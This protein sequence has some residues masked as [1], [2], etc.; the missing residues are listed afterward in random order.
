MTMRHPDMVSASRSTL[1][2]L[3]ALAALVVLGGCISAPSGGPA[4]DASSP[5]GTHDPTGTIGTDAT[6]PGTVPTGECDPVERA[7][8][9]P[10]R[11]DLSPRDLPA[12]P[13][14][15]DRGSV[16]EYVVAFEKAYSHNDALSKTSTRVSV[17]VYDVEVRATDRGWVVSL[18]S[19]TN[20]WAAG[21]N[22]AGGTPTVVHG[23]GH[24]VPV[25]YHLF[26]DR[27]YRVEFGYDATP[28]DE[29]GVVVACPG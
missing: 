16:R 5:Q 15:R 12:P 8:V 13:S 14:S 1:A 25:T 23:D 7:T 29:L 24:R 26:A 27:L 28:G 17:S 11:E 2:I 9:D 10:V 18:V 21:T 19:V 20:T 6:S 22:S 3:V 4:T